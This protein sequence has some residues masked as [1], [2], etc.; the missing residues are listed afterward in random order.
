ME[1]YAYLNDEI[2]N[3]NFNVR[4]FYAKRIDNFLELLEFEQIIN[5]FIPF[6]TKIILNKEKNEEVLTEYAK[7]LNFI[8]EYIL[9]HKYY[10]IFRN[11]N[12]LLF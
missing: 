3:I 7:K 8:I 4:I 2:Q 9:E 1:K 11:V 5:D 10:S 6:I 12:K